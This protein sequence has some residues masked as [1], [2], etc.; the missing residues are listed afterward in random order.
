[1]TPK[2]DAFMEESEALRKSESYEDEETLFERGSNGFCLV[3]LTV[4][5]PRGSSQ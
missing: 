4:Q 3:T 1:M 5:G 2:S